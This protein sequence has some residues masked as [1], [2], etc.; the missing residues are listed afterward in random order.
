MTKH[1]ILSAFVATLVISVVLAVVLPNYFLMTTPIEAGLMLAKVRGQ[2]GWRAARAPQF[3]RQ[4]GPG[5]R[6]G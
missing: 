5:M 2:S 6:A 3:P 4:A 1:P